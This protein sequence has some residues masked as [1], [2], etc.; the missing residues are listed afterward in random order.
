V[1]KFTIITVLLFYSLATLGVSLNY[2]YCCGKLKEV[3][4]NLNPPVAHKC[5]MKGGKD[6]CKNEKVDIQISAD[7]NF[8]QQ[9]SF[10]PLVFVGVPF[11]NHFKFTNNSAGGK[12]KTYA[13]NRPPPLSHPQL[14]VINCSFL[15]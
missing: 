10:E 12:Y 5:S 14:H 15:I 9:I 3:T 11:L 4:V 8:S 2:L 1:K 6:C 7:Q 13:Q